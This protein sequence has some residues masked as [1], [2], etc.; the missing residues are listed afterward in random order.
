MKDS[1]S[2][3][4]RSSTTE[5]TPPVCPSCHSTATVTAATRPDADSYWRCTNCG[6]VWNVTRSHTDRYGGHRWR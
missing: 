6:N 1:A 4:S 5:T 3:P 2:N